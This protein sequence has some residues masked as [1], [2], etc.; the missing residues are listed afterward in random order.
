M[1][2]GEGEGAEPQQLGAAPRGE[3]DETVWRG[4]ALQAEEKI[5][6]LEKSLAELRGELESAKATLESMQKRRELEQQ[7][8]DAKAQDVE[9]A[10]M[11][12]EKTLA[13]APDQDIGRAVADVKQRKPHL[14][15]PPAPRGSGAAG[16]APRAEYP[17]AVEEAFAKARGAGGTRRSLLDYLRAKRRG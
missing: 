3:S 5:K 6:E 2:T 11:L 8:I 1:P 17:G 14:F 12:V 15:E 10:L 16:P 4:R 7:L 9:T 13:K